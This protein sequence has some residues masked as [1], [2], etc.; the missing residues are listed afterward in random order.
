M[1]DY[2]CPDCNEAKLQSDKNARKINEVIDQ[3][4]ALIQVNNGTVDFIEE[5]AEE[6]VEEI[7]GIKVNE[8]LGELNTEI[9]NME[10]H[11]YGKVNVKEFGAKGDGVTD[12]TDVIQRALIYAYINGNSNVFFPSG[13]YVISKPLYIISNRYEVS[14]GFYIQGENQENTKIICRDMENITDV[15]PFNVKAC[16]VIVN[17]FILNE[18]NEI[19]FTKFDYSKHNS[20]GRVHVSDLMLFSDDRSGE[21]GLYFPLNTFSCTFK[22]MRIRFFTEAG[23]KNIDHLY[24][25]IFEQIRVDNGKYGISIGNG[26]I[27]TSNNFIS[28]YI[29]GAEVGYKIAGVY[30]HMTNCCADICSNIVFDLTGFRGT[31]ESPGSESPEAINVFVGG[32]NTHATIINPYTYGNFDNENAFHIKANAGARMKF[33]GGYLLVDDVIGNRTAP[34]GLYQLAT[35][36]NVTFDDVNYRPFIKVNSYSDL[37]VNNEYKTQHG[38]VNTRHS[39]KISY[40]G[41]DGSGGTDREKKGFVEGKC[42]NSKIMGNAI[43]FNM[44]S[45]IG[46]DSQGTDVRY[47]QPTKKGDIILSKNPKEMGGIGWIQNSDNA[48]YWENGEFL[49]IPILLSGS[50]EQ[51]PTRTDLPTGFCYFDT[52]LNKPI[53]LANNND[54]NGRRWRDSNGNLV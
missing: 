50:T 44:G 38:R 41:Y 37:T 15:S 7:A 31:V 51:R 48:E 49:T 34:G 14:G 26:G 33:I 22:R 29:V 17:Q 43:Y 8:V 35:L 9:D 23:I 28:C 45:H 52:T 19:D 25:N 4:N 13:Q 46:W 16:F 53:W 5:K 10:K 12:D 40:I 2:N 42:E 47:C 6:K 24:L 21:I 18:N 39:G 54:G 11:I 30:S 20:T 32:Q 1:Y 36:T 27:C 3:V